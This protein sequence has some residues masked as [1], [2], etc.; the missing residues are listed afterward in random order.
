MTR[1]AGFPPLVL[2]LRLAQRGRCFHCGEPMRFTSGNHKLRWS[3]EHL[4]PRANYGPAT[5][6]VLAHR[7]CN[8]DRHDAEPTPDEIERARAIYAVAG[9]WFHTPAD[10]HI[11]AAGPGLGLMGE[12]WPTRPAEAERAE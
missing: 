11:P 4:F 7:G 10:L 2:S 5:C 8:S 12:I 6:F 9:A 3:R 1:A